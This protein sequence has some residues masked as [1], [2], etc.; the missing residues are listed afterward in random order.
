MTEVEVTAKYEILPYLESSLAQHIVPENL[1]LL[2]AALEV[3]LP[4]ICKSK[5]VE[6]IQTDITMH[7]S[8]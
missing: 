4:R 6:N 7:S 2:R 1:S 5:E 3:R 8:P